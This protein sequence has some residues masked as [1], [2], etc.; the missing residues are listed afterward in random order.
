M[1]HTSDQMSDTGSAVIEI[2][3]DIVT[4]RKLVRAISAQV[5]FVGTDITRVVTAAAELTRNIY[6]Y[7]GSGVM[8]WKIIRT[9]AHHG[10]ELVFDDQGP[11]IPDVEAALTPG[12]T[13]GNG[14]GM[15]LPG[16][17]R[18]MDEMEIW[19]ELGKGTR[20]TVRKWK[21]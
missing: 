18:L 13:T 8:R 4:V 17:K 11:G 7:A 2:E 14:L 3:S 6:K 10:L 15:G 20:V 21:N 5:G 1:S 19:S 16:T 12:Y 9:S